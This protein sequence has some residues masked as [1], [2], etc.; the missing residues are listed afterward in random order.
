M[1]CPRCASITCVM[2]TRPAGE[3]GIDIGRR[4][5]CASCDYTFSTR[6]SVDP[7]LVVKRRDTPQNTPLP[8]QETPSWLKPFV[9]DP[10]LHG[11]AERVVQARSE[12]AKPI[13]TRRP[14]DAPISLQQHALDTWTHGSVGGTMPVNNPPE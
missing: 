2:E 9:D 5:R 1:L 10:T 11:N 13:R 8:P 3:S 7:T 6:E 4:R 12:P 14:L